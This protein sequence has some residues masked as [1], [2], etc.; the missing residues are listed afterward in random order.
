MAEHPTVATRS[1]D[2]CRKWEHNET[3]GKRIE[4][5][6]GTPRLRIIQSTPPCEDERG[7]PKGHWREPL[8]LTEQNWQAYVFHRR[9]KAVNRWP[10]DEIVELNAAIIEAAH[11]LG[12][13]NAPARRWKERN[14]NNGTKQ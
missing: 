13:R 2:D 4:N 7:C 9:C 6:D 5:Q 1:C 12:T 14:G 10:E 11:N 3:D 8:E